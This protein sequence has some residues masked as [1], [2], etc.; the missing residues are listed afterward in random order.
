[1]GGYNPGAYVQGQP[2]MYAAGPQQHA[3]MYGMPQQQQQQQ[4]QQQQPPQQQQQQLQ[5]MAQQGM[6]PSG[7]RTSA[8]P[9]SQG[10]GYAGGVASDRPLIA[11]RAVR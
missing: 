6:A 10:G 11:A 8:G 5:G 4:P 7:Q 9:R 3:A 1:M 2:G